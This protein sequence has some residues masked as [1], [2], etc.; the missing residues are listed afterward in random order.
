MHYCTTLNTWRKRILSGWV[1]ILLALFLA[2]PAKTVEPAYARNKV[3][4]PTINELKAI[5]LYNF[6]KFVQWPENTCKIHDGRTRL[7]SVL[8]D[9]PFNKILKAMQEKLKESD[10]D[11][12]LIFHGP[13]RKDMEFTCCCLMFIT[14]SEQ[15]NLPAILKKLAGKPILTVSDLE[16][17]YDQGIMIT[18]VTY[19]NRIR[20]VINRQPV[21]KSGLKLSS[22]L[23]DIATKVIDEEFRSQN[24]VR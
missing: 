18:M 24:L 20:W 21:N 5:Y 10:K 11:F 7:I 4:S 6:L 12:Q 2:C 13:Y 8:G 23:L 17:L 16:S 15:T 1:C 22:K 9:S 14:A 19:E 3:N